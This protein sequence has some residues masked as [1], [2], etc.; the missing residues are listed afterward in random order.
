M[1]K[2]PHALKNEPNKILQFNINIRSSSFNAFSIFSD[3]NTHCKYAIEI[4][5]VH[6]FKTNIFAIW[7]N[8]T[9][10][11]WII[12]LKFKAK[13]S[14][15]SSFVSSIICIYEISGFSQEVICWLT[16]FAILCQLY[17]KTLNHPNVWHDFKK[18]SAEIFL[19]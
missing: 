2:V 11:A 4:R 5:T 15:G 14:T 1:K 6:I 10:S 9:V 13:V 12:D 3:E 17:Q 8:F 18:Y 19:F 16:L 7:L